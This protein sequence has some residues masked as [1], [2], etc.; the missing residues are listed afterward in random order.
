MTAVTAIA[1][2]LTL[3]SQ[4]PS[5]AALD[6][7]ALFAVGLEH[8]RE[9]AHR[10]WTD[11]NVHDPGITTLE[12]LC[13]ALTDLA[14]RAGFPIPDLLARPGGDGEGAP[15][16]FTARRI[17]PARP[18]TAVDYRKLVI[19]LAGV[20]NAWI[21]PTTETYFADTII[22]E[23]RRDM[24]ADPA[25]IIPVPLQGLYD[26]LL[27]FTGDVNTDD[28]R[29]VVRRRALATLHGNRNLCEDFVDV[30]TVGVQQFILCAE[31]ELASDADV[32]TT[33]ARVLF[34]V[35]Q[36]LSPPVAQYTLDEIAARPNADGT[37]RTTDQIFDG[38]ALEHGFIDDDELA[39]AELR[40]E[41]RLSDVI[42]VVM[43][44]PGVR[45]VRDIIVSPA[46]PDGPG[47]AP[48]PLP[49]KWLVPVLDERRP[50]LDWARC[51]LVC[52]K[53]GMPFVAEPLDV[54]AQRQQLE[55]AVSALEKTSRADDYP[56]PAGR[57]RDLE[58]YVSF[59]NHFPVTYGLGEF[60][61]TGPVDERRRAQAR[62]L[63]GYLLLFDQL[64]ADF[65]AQLAHVGDLFAT[66]ATAP[67]IAR[68]WF[69]QRLGEESLR[70]AD[71]IYAPDVDAEAIASAVDSPAAQ[72]D[73]KNRFLDHLIARVAERFGEFT[74]IMRSQ[75]GTS[76]AAMISYKCD[77]LGDYAEV[78]AARGLGYD[79]TRQD[80]EGLWDSDN[81]SGL[82]RRLARLLGIPNFRRRNLGNVSYDIYSEL[83]KTPDDEFRFRVMRR[84]SDKIVLSG[85]QN[86]A[87]RDLARAAMRRAIAEATA[88]GSYVRNVSGDG[89]HYFTIVDAS[90]D[91][92]AWRDEFFTTPDAMNAAIAE[93]LEYLRTEYSDEGMYVIEAILLRPD[94]AQ[95]DDPFLP[96]CPDPDCT[97][98]ADEDPYSYRLHI[99]LPAYA[100]R[101]GDM[102]FR[103]WAEEVI[104]EEVPAHVEP[105]ICWIGK[106][107][108]AELERRYRDWIYL[109]AG[110]ET[111]DRTKKLT[112]LRDTLFRVRNVYPAQRLNECD[113]PASVQKFILGQT[114]LGTLSDTT[115]G[116]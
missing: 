28:E 113:A 95:P 73:R 46:P 76:P 49:D 34:E 42:H 1:A 90:G 35:D 10:I 74:E 51:R 91:V 80:D 89:R 37:P 79:Y 20:D 55:A 97:D 3:P 116:E 86:Y 68:T 56:I 31:L 24:P 38:P 41:I 102:K 106:D 109:R 96:I 44:V 69:H 77:F 83:D 48:A 6:D 36:F 60:G 15:P 104:R 65:V 75:F 93:L 52:Y 25:G 21:V 50:R 84:D 67:D 101:F 39:A 62:Q 57:V 17:L 66:D 13:Y 88:P 63:K 12:L 14:Y 4:R 40:K 58:R 23:L 61:I 26:V 110:R 100:G 81:V 43:D 53:R 99:V 19:D 94:P 111:A 70:E 27:A 32:A 47:T 87:T 85:T 114:A 78:S 92:L 54:D 105:R 2:P 7:Q 30:R 115:P 98:C 9:L 103:R 33:H 107:D 29:D 112:M 8:V 64:M 16:F 72:V 5:E 18:L 22:G 11:H 45:A 108:M 59:Q 71:L 82:E